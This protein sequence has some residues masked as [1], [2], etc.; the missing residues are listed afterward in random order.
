ML[1]AYNSSFYY[2]FSHYFLALLLF[3]FVLLF[4]IFLLEVTSYYITMTHTTNQITAWLRDNWETRRKD[5][6]MN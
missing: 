2:F 5:W 1:C 3:H 6:E 4:N